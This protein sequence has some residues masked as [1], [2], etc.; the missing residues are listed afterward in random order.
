MLQ[1][2][3][4]DLLGRVKTLK[5]DTRAEINVIVCNVVILMWTLFPL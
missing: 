5:A 3:R 4:A 1:C 2:L